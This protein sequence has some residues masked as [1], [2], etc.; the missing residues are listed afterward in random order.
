MEK[1]KNWH[2]Q[3]IAE[4]INNTPRESD[5]TSFYDIDVKLTDIKTRYHF[6][7]GGGMT[8]EAEKERL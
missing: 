3:F 4:F 6:I 2:H 7:C 5:E 8:T 1:N